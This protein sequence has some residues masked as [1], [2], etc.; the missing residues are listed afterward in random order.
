MLIYCVIPG[1]LQ[2]TVLWQVSNLVFDGNAFVSSYSTF[3]DTLSE[4]LH[5][6]CSYRAYC[7]P[8]PVRTYS[9]SRGFS[10][11]QSSFTNVRWDGRAPHLSHQPKHDH[12]SM[13]GRERKQIL[14]VA[15]LSPRP[16][17]F[18]L[19]VALNQDLSSDCIT[20]N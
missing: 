7:T 2:Y 5:K 13:E 3:V 12:I 19:S 8:L 17:S 14:A 4:E 6:H 1:L 11:P 18:I 10:F 16:V 9:R 20:L 15:S